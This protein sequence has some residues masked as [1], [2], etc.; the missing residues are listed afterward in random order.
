MGA[1]VVG[2]LKE[3][4]FPVAGINVGRPARQRRLFANLRAEGYWRL[5]ELFK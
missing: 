1:G 5:Y 3:L 4:N 2:R